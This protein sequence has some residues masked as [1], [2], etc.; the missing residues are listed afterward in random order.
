[1]NIV[2]YHGRFNPPHVGHLN[3][4]E[5]L[6]SFAKSEGAVVRIALSPTHD[7]EKNPLDW[8]TKRVYVDAMVEPFGF[9]V[10]DKPVSSIYELV[11]DTAFSMG[12]G[13]LILVCGA[14]RV[15]SYTGMVASAI[16]KYQSRGE[17]LG[18]EAS[19]TSLMER[20][21]ADAFSATQMREMAAK[22]DFAGFMAKIPFKDKQLGKD[23]YDDVR[24]G[25]GLDESYAEFSRNELMLEAQ[26]SSSLDSAMGIVKRMEEQVSEHENQMTGEPD[27][28]YLIGGAVRDLLTGKTPSDL[29]LITTMYYKDYAALFGT[30]D[31]RF[32]GKQIIVV[33]V[34]D[35]EEFE[36]ACLQK[37][38]TLEENLKY[39]DLTINSMA[40]NP[41]TEEVIDPEGGR[42]DLSAKLIN[43]TDF[44]A[45]A[46]SA[47]GQP[48]AVLRTI[49]FFA[50]YGWT[51][52]PRTKAA[53]VS[54]AKKNKG[55]LRV[56]TRQFEK[57][58]HKLERGANKAGALKLIDEL[59]FTEFLK[60]TQPLFN[61]GADMEVG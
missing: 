51:M 55:Q 8:N 36:T 23:M 7:S 34:V 1:M 18:I 53:L 60:K 30:D 26:M 46:I 12:K 11:R 61:D 5:R 2:L 35:G 3:L 43:L 40:M 17:L 38:Q 20:G 32:R 45:D 58:W 50:T 13:R 59:G 56:T 28:L 52:T 29:D 24:A 16:K 21:D 19:V 47:G 41:L 4:C 54:F 37:G 49:R 42:G 57:D 31:V 25:L 33:P 9:E 27:H 48:V 6:A 15:K 10:I 22:G 44:M 39:R 14:D